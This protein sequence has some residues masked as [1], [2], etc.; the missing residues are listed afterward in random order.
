MNLALWKGGDIAIF[1]DATQQA[2][3][4]TVSRPTEWEQTFTAALRQAANDDG[5]NNRRRARHDPILRSAA[6]LELRDLTGAYHL[7]REGLREAPD[8]THR[9]GIARDGGAILCAF[10]DLLARA[11]AAHFAVDFLREAVTAAP[12]AADLR[13]A[14]GRACVSLGALEASRDYFGEALAAYETALTISAADQTQGG[15]AFRSRVTINKAIALWQRAELHKGASADAMLSEAADLL[16]RV[17][18]ASPGGNALVARI[19]SFRAHE[20]LGNI[21]VKEG[22][23]AEALTHLSIARD[24][25]STAVD[26]ARILNNIGAAHSGHHQ[27]DLALEAYSAAIDLLTRDKTPV[28]WSRTQ[29]NRGD[30]LRMKSRNED[31]PLLEEAI[32]VLEEAREVCTP[33]LSRSLRS[34]IN[35][36]LGDAVGVLSIVNSDSVLRDNALYYYD[37]ATSDADDIRRSE[38]E[39]RRANISESFEAAARQRAIMDRRANILSSVRAALHAH[40]ATP[41]EWADVSAQISREFA[42][43]SLGPSGNP[44]EPSTWVQR[45]EGT[46]P[47]RQAPPPQTVLPMPT[48]E[49]LRRE[50]KLYSQA[51][52]TAKKAGRKYDIIDHLKT[53]WMPWI[54]AGKLSRPMLDQRGDRANDDQSVGDRSAYKALDEWCRREGN[55]L[56]QALGYDIPSKQDL[57]DRRAAEAAA[58]PPGDRPAKIGWAEGKRRQKQRKA[59]QDRL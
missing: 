1:H 46:S 35:I 29:R 30:A 17:M 45:V 44:G 52:A 15:V 26:R 51:F 11:D 24:A 53:V 4:R 27:I 34:L 57:V 21:L 7:L 19:D 47:P 12:D 2:M 18:N 14:L 49:D 55:D 48:T 23:I 28:E 6:R 13:N 16:R 10:A 59:T 31:R 58:L 54:E 33:T 9:R 41:D 39:R 25:A 36:S 5:H 50:G 40:Q 37:I 56:K 38:I 22:G 3:P 8:D 20:T 43:A 42:D 32:S